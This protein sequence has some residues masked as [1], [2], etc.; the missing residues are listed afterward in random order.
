MRLSGVAGLFLVLGRLVALAAAALAI[1]LMAWWGYDLWH[2]ALFSEGSPWG[3]VGVSPL[4]VVL[5][6]ALAGWVAWGV[7]KLGER[8]LLRVLLAAFGVS[9]LLLYGWYYALLGFDNAFFYW[10]VAGDLLYLAGAL[11]VG[12]ALLSS[13]SESRSGNIQ[14]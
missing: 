9:F 6:I 8:A 2:Y 1:G 5:R 11:A 12:C 10:V 4:V 13:A 7:V 3:E 14:T